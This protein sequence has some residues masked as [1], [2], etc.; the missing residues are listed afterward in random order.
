M[1]PLP[2]PEG[3]ENMNKRDWAIEETPSIEADALKKDSLTA[4]LDN[5]VGFEAIIGRESRAWK[6][7]LVW[8]TISHSV[9]AGPHVF[10][11]LGV[12]LHSETGHAQL[13]PKSMV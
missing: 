3:P 2:A 10:Q 1:V 6:P 12:T 13:H 9:A 8:L 5:V 4:D 7:T 11:R